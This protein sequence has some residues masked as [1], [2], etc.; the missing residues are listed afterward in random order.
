MVRLHREEGLSAL[1]SGALPSLALVSNPAIKFTVYEWLKRALLLRVRRQ[2][3]QQQQHLDGGQAFLLGVAASLAATVAT[4]P[5]QVVQ[6]KSRVNGVHFP[7]VIKN[8]STVLIMFSLMTNFQQ[9]TH[10]L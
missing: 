9:A 4:Y 6:A 5:L 3:Q 8:I 1:W 10:Q 7:L 2:Q